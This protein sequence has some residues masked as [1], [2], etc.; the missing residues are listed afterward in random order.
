MTPWTVACQ[1]PLSMEFSRQQYWSEL[2]CPAPGDLPN[3]GIEPWS[4]E[5]WTA[6]LWSGPPGKIGLVK[7]RTASISPLNL[8]TQQVCSGAWGCNLQQVPRRCWCS[9]HEDHILSTSHCTKPTDPSTLHVLQS[10]LE[11]L[12]NPTSV[13]MFLS[14]SLVER[15]WYWRSSSETHS[16]WNN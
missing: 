1:A 7:H 15:G 16:S 4:P 8:L 9:W 11:I 14:S 12:P 13:L 10:Q 3:P 5:Q 6:S 2:P